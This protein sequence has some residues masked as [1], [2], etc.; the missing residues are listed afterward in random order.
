MPTLETLTLA[1]VEQIMSPRVL[2]R[3]FEYVARV[4]DA[5]RSGKVLTAQVQGS[6]MYGVEVEVG[7]DI[8]A[9][10]SCPYEYNGYCK[11]IGAVLLKWLQSP[12][13]F[14]C[15]EP[16]GMDGLVEPEPTYR[17]AHY[18]LWVGESAAHGGGI[19]DDFQLVDAL[20]GIALADLRGVARER[21]WRIK[22]TRKDDVIDQLV[23]KLVD[24]EE[25]RKCLSSLDAECRHVYYAMVL[26]G[27][28]AA[29]EQVS[30]LTRLRYRSAGEAGVAG[31]MGHLGQ[32]GLSL[33]PV[34]GG[35][36]DNHVNYG[37]GFVP[38]AIAREVPPVPEEVIAS[39]EELRSGEAA[40][41]RT[42]DA[43]A[44]VRSVHQVLSL[45]EH[46]PVKLRPGRSRPEAPIHAG[47]CDGWDYDPE[48][49]RQAG[50]EGQSQWRGLT[51]LSVPPPAWHL[52][53]ETIEWLAPLSG[54]K[55][56]LEFIYAQLVAAGV[57]QPGSPV[58]VWPEVKEQFLCRPVQAQ[59]AILARTYFG[60][61]DWSELWEMLRS[62]E[63]LQLRRSLRFRLTPA[64]LKQALLAAR[65]TVL[66]V[67]S[68]LPDDRWVRL[69]DL[70]PVL[71]AV[72]RPFNSGS[73]AAT[74]YY[75][76]G[77]PYVWQLRRKSTSKPLLFDNDADW[78]LSGWNFVLHVLA[79]PLHWLGLVDLCVEDGALT[80]I[81][82]HG[83]GDLF[84]GRAEA[85]SATG[86]ET[87][88]VVRVG[89]DSVRFDGE[90]ILADP[91]ALRPEV[92]K[93]FKSI[94]RLVETTPQCF[95]YELDV[96]SAYATF[97][98]GQT[99][100]DILAGWDEWLAVPVPA[101]IRD[102]LVRWWEGYGQVRIYEDVSIIEFSDDYALT[103]MK[104]VTSLA[105]HLIVEISPRL[106]LVAP[107]TV[108]T[109]TAELE[110]AGYTPQQG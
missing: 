83:L 98:A 7:P 40:T 26:A 20:R 64:Q 99:L 47:I 35:Y 36:G 68:L 29:P 6:R 94:A 79:G 72:L 48:E 52:P 104:T 66:R 95:S 15:A 31:H 18:P 100:D 41:L 86:S 8:A 34:A 85:L 42:A 2:D 3:A 25:I 101:A 81:R 105:K 77:T 89:E 80:E 69:S 65:R 87:G 96:R 55:A 107:G 39:R 27:E 74:A 73:Y 93:L 97:E 33:G 9:Q 32:L 61:A 17:P 78:L 43:V 90:R 49:L 30:R 51:E 1:D 102:R 38:R 19:G 88:K 106:V 24:G 92:Y 60:N 75:Y 62:Q 108:D 54:G 46:N 23:P 45:L 67:L 59:R 50:A 58:T 28:R 4:S 37:A 76:P 14:A 21:G 5:A 109:L 22:G 70:Q 103:E 13:S 63:E 71:R 82:L 12:G 91:T 56:R 11:H 57:F 10:C 16:G 110:K 84:W 44:L 53:D